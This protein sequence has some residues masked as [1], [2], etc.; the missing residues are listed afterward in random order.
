MVLVRAIS[1]ITQE[2]SNKHELKKINN[3]LTKL[4]QRKK[5]KEKAQVRIVDISFI[6]ETTYATREK[7]RL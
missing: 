5:E 7:N 1:I 2:K 6:V 3:P 4:S